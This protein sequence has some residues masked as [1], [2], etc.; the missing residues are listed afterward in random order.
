MELGVLITGG[1][2]PQDAE[3]HFDGLIRAG[4]LVPVNG[5]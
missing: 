2:P 3:R 4:V 1:R 5:R